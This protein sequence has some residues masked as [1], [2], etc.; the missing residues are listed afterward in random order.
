MM[1]GNIMKLLTIFTLVTLLVLVTASLLVP[2]FA[3]RNFFNCTTRVANRT[4]SL[5]IDEVKICYDKVFIGARKTL[6][7]RISSANSTHL[8]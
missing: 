8:Q 6:Q 1:D 5:T 7:N 2:A 3:L 4:G